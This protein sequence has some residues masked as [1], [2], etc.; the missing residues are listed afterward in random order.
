[1]KNVIDRM[2]EN[3]SE[4]KI[5]AFK[6]KQGLPYEAKLLHA[7]NLARDFY[8]QME[9]M[10]YVAVGGLDSITLYLFLQSIGLK[11][12]AVSVSVLEDKSIQHIH[13]ALGIETLKPLKSKVEVIREF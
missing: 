6:Q 8:D 10:C 1:M 4:H 13:K 7:K 5:Q 3:K 9:G 2:K 12:P 11:I